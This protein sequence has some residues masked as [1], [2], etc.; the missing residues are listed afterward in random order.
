MKKLLVSTALTTAFALAA[1]PALAQTTTDPVAPAPVEE[2][3]AANSDSMFLPGVQ[4]GVRASDFIGKRVYVTEADT[5][6]MSATAIAEAGTDWED[7]GEI[8]DLIISMGGDTQAVLVDF[9][10]FLG[11]GEKTVA[12]SLADLTMV[13]DANSAD[14]YFIVFHGTKADLEAAPEFDPDMVFAATDDSV[15]VPDAE[16]GAV[17]DTLMGTDPD[18]GMTAETTPDPAAD[19]SADPAASGDMAAGEATTDPAADP[20]ASGDTGMTAETTADPAADP[21]ASGEIAAGEAVDLAAWAE[22][23]LIGKRVYGPNDEDIGEIAAVTLD[24]SGTVEA[25]VVDVGGFLGIGEKPVALG[26]DMLT[27]VQEADGTV[28]FRVA[29]TQEELEAMAPHA[30]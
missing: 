8:G 23:D 22:A 26:D 3:P 15:V 30:G 5:T 25:A 2:A 19:P 29:A 9:G 1:V 24:D 7:A 27:L 18:T 13:P 12:L 16:T 6:G 10:G 28:Y 17:D 4:D 14:D 20:A 11:I 21:A